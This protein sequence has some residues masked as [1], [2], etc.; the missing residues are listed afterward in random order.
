MA[1]DATLFTILIKDEESKI[2]VPDDFSL[3]VVG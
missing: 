3:D 1:K 2:Y